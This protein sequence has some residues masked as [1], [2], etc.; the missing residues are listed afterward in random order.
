[1]KKMMRA[2]VLGASVLGI[3][4]AMA[5]AASA[6]SA[7]DTIHGGCFF[8]TDENAIATNGQN[9]GSI[10]DASA[11]T[12]PSGAPTGASV[13]CWIRVNGNKQNQ[14]DHTYTGVGVQGGQDQIVFTADATATVEL[15]EHVVYAD[16][17]TED[18]CRVATSQNIPPDAVVA[19]LNSIFDQLDAFEK[20]NV[21]PN[22]CPVL[23]ALHNAIPGGGIP[24]VLW[25]DPEG[26]V[27][28]ADPLSLGL[29]PFWECYPYGD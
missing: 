16:T 18:S 29:N 13:E 14:T 6:N 28:V 4:G 12:D 1:M 5:P 10:G 22:V 20:Q 11:T 15:C 23:V 9:Q 24:G 25:I 7:G 21:D 3:V 26:D 27:Y 2:A 19:L 8:N 17:T